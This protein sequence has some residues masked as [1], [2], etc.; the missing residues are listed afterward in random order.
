MDKN[1]KIMLVSG[2]NHL[3][4]QVVNFITIHWQAYHHCPEY[5]GRLISADPDLAAFAMLE[6]KVV[7]FLNATRA[8]D[9]GTHIWISL[10]LVHPDFRRRGIGRAIWDK[11]WTT[12]KEK[13]GMGNCP[14]RLALA[15]WTDYHIRHF[16]ENYG[17]R[18]LT[19]AMS[20]SSSETDWDGTKWMGVVRSAAVDA[21]EK[22][23]S[24]SNLASN[25]EIEILEFPNIN[26]SIIN[27]DFSLTGLHRGQFLTHWASGA[28]IVM[29]CNLQGKICGYSVLLKLEN[30][31]YIPRLLCN[32]VHFRFNFYQYGT[33]KIHNLY[34]K[35]LYHLSIS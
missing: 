2:S 34:C 17:F 5:I 32:S 15:T 28:I 26:D 12:I 13:C 14:L 6:D 23:L 4:E 3:K 8:D 16:Y 24:I 10:F 25:D 1:L 18:H 31:Y 9:S 20:S 11:L 33:Y 22:E 35:V 21:L 7:G 30:G 19:T 27:F 29:A